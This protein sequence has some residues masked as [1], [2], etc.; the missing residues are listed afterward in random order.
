M[1]PN[2]DFINYYFINKK[3]NI[4]NFSNYKLIETFA[5]YAKYADNF[6]FKSGTKNIPEFKNK[7]EFNDFLKKNKDVRIK[8]GSLTDSEL[9]ELLSE[10][11]FKSNEIDSKNLLI[12]SDGTST[13]D[14]TDLLNSKDGIKQLNVIQ[15]RVKSGS[16]FTEA[17]K[18]LDGIRGKLDANLQINSPALNSLAL[19]SPTLNIDINAPNNVKQIE[20]NDA[21]KAK[22]FETLETERGDFID[23]EV[24]KLNNAKTIDDF[25]NIDGENIDTKIVN[26]SAK[27]FLD[28]LNIEELVHGTTKRVTLKINDT[29]IEVDNLGWNQ[30]IGV[31][32]RKVDGKTDYYTYK[33]SEAGYDGDSAQTLNDFLKQPANRKQLLD[34]AGGKDK[35]NG[36]SMKLKLEE[37]KLKID[38]NSLEAPSLEG[39]LP[40]SPPA[41]IA[42]AD[43]PTD[44]PTLKPPEGG[45][46]PSSKNIPG[47]PEG[48]DPRT[49]PIPEAPPIRPPPPHPNAI[50]KLKSLK[51]IS[52]MFDVTDIPKTNV[53][54][55]TGESNT[56]LK[57]IFDTQKRVNNIKDDKIQ[58][59]KYAIGNKDV[60][61]EA[62]IP[63]NG[64]VAVGKVNGQDE[65]YV[66]TYKGGD[67]ITDFAPNE[68]SF[69]S[70]KKLDQ[71]KADIK[72]WDDPTL[73]ANETPNPGLTD[74]DV[75]ISDDN[76]KRLNEENDAIYKLLDN[77]SGNR[78]SNPKKITEFPTENTKTTTQGNYNKMGRDPPKNFTFKEKPTT[79]K[80]DAE[81][82]K[83]IVKENN[84]KITVENTLTADY[85]TVR[86]NLPRFAY[87]F[88][89]ASVVGAGVGVGFLVDSAERGQLNKDTCKN[90]VDFWGK[91]NTVD[92]TIEQNED[93]WK[94]KEG[95]EDMCPGNTHYKNVYEWDESKPNG[96]KCST[97][98]WVS[99]FNSC[100]RKCD[101]GDIP[102][103]Y[104]LKDG[105]YICTDNPDTIKNCN[106]D[107]EGTFEGGTEECK[108]DGLYST[109]KIT[110]K[111]IGNGKCPQKDTTTKIGP[112]NAVNCEGKYDDW[113][114]CKSNGKRT[115]TYTITT[116]KKYGGTECT[117][118]TELEESC[119][120]TAPPDNQNCEGKWSELTACID[121]KRTKKYTITK[122]K[123][124]NGESCKDDKGNELKDGDI[125]TESCTN[126][127][128]Y[129]SDWS[130]CDSS[131]D[132]HRIYSI[133]SAAANGGTECPFEHGYK[134]TKNPKDTCTPI[135][136]KTN[137]VGQ[138]T[139]Y[140]PCV[141][142]KQK[143]SYLI[144]TYESNGGEKCK[145][146][147]GNELQNGSEQEKDCVEISSTE[148]NFADKSD[149][150]K[151]LTDDELNELT[152]DMTDDE[153]KLYIIL[154]NTV[155]DL[156]DEEF[157]K[158]KKLNNSD[159][160]IYLLD[161]FGLKPG[162]DGTAIP[163]VVFN[164]SGIDN[165]SDQ[166]PNLQL[167][168][169]Q[170]NI[171]WFIPIIAGFVLFLIILFLIFK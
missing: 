123:G 96:Q 147:K 131:G 50:K 163:Q 95:Q 55:N 126:C 18:K 43:V 7:A 65:Y 134:E 109:F 148:R 80:T 16:N 102:G 69:K 22:S 159:K 113:G 136:A 83:A 161:L 13:F 107:C 118:N 110:T 61:F 111:A 87:A 29:D 99:E 35:L 17:T 5:N 153:K 86:A 6:E 24:G 165:S 66:F 62:I 51:N 77:W 121:N 1:N 157:E 82:K 108:Q 52:V 119:T 37:G 133:Y 47:P 58:P 124:T 20:V 164:E 72:K 140:G 60:E 76:I 40:F 31:F 151:G 64:K 94:Y 15:F 79:Q 160:I 103:K 117:N 149:D 67:G 91:T 120:Y 88:V 125:K 115:R 68:G 100:S 44:T 63:G 33:Y 2:T 135:T 75:S 93:C 84:L 27:K 23:N 56:I 155:K 30:G 21:S 8:T 162:T 169:F 74:S 11:D 105:E 152:K 57:R 14:V 137:C 112:C 78:L 36:K 59:I 46:A 98:K 90:N 12:K 166:Q 104:E 19:N 144:S 154:N 127:T 101:N 171:N 129:F 71:N 9:T 138:W 139:K 97:E 142:K 106:R 49:L 92:N 53:G 73:K 150:K 122:E 128:G 26:A 42:R 10:I 48:T 141:G 168:F 54:K 85:P 81:I 116:A 34:W 70:I 89:A 28:D 39:I 130:G 158:Y 45:L 41:S 146:D 145:D 38:L 170:E 114:A 156:S 25:T 3:N 4:E 132:K 143:R 167:D 32:Q